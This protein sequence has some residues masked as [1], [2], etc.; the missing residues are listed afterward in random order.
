LSSGVSESK[1]VLAAAQG[2][3]KKREGLHCLQGGSART[4]LMQPLSLLKKIESA[5][6][7]V[8]RL[9]TAKNCCSFGKE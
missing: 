3:S 8:V 9:E 5:K 4:N 2:R 7:K 1:I 6:C